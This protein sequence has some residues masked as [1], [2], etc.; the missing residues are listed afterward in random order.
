MKKLSLEQTKTISI[1]LLPQT[2]IPPPADIKRDDIRA[3]F[4]TFD[5]TIFLQ[6]RNFKRAL[7]HI[8]NDERLFYAK[9]TVAE[10]ARKDG[11]RIGKEH[12]V[13]FFTDQRVL[14]VLDSGRVF[15]EFAL[16][17]IHSVASKKKG[18]VTGQLSFCTDTKRVDF[19]MSSSEGITYQLVEA[20]LI[21]IVAEFAPALYLEKM[22]NSQSIDAV[23]L[24]RLESSIANK[25]RVVECPGCSANNIIIP[26]LMGKCEYCDRFID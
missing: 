20:T 26:G 9:P 8:R 19:D 14:I 13:I 4:K 12:C 24:A 21:R 2:R 18:F 15:D 6:G 10:I 23:A 22:K 7:T 25:A 16:H 3:L 17:D 11:T 5:V 1:F